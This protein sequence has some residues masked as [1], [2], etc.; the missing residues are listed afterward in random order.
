LSEGGS[1]PQTPTSP[2][3]QR[4]FKKQHWAVTVI[5]NNEKWPA[6]PRVPWRQLRVPPKQFAS[7]N[8]SRSFFACL[9]SRRCCASQGRG[10]LQPLGFWRGS[11]S[12]FLTFSFAALAPAS[13][14]QGIHQK[15]QTQQIC[16]DFRLHLQ[17][18]WLRRQTRQRMTLRYSENVYV[19]V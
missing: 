5:S 15:Q 2:R 7:S 19:W 3:F 10:T 1:A 11:S 9:A 4:V 18:Q 16:T 14:G 6:N 13:L 17:R 12:G 8:L